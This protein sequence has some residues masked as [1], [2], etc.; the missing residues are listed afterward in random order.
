M[1][2]TSDHS[3]LSPQ[4]LNRWSPRSYTSDDIPEQDLRTLFE[5]AR[6]APSCF[7]EQP[8]LFA[9]AKGSGPD[10]PFWNVLVEGNQKWAHPCPVIILAFAKKHFA[11]DGRINAWAPFDTGAAWMSLALQAHL[12]GFDAHGMGGFDQKLAYEKADVDPE[13]YEVMCAIV[14]GKRLPTEAESPN[15]RKPL[16]N[17]IKKID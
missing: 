12:M 14:V 4:F 2:R 3:K 1:T 5:A 13:K 11:M 8:W 10:N 9:Y 6:W 16:S 17:M 15:E 7:N